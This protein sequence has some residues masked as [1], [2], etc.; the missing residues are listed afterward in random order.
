MAK[1]ADIKTGFLCNNN[2][3]FRVHADNKFKGNRRMEDVSKDMEDA[4]KTGCDGFSMID[5]LLYV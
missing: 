2:C 4:R 5:S 1:R 3:R